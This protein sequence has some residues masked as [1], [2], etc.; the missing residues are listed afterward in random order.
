[1]SIRVRGTLA[2]ADKP[3]NEKV[4]LQARV[5][6]VVPCAWLSRLAQFRIAPNVERLAGRDHPT[7]AGATGSTEQAFRHAARPK[8][9]R[10]SWGSP[11]HRTANQRTARPAVQE[12]GEVQNHRPLGIAPRARGQGEGTIYRAGN[13]RL[14]SH[15]GGGRAGSRRHGSAQHPGEP[16]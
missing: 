8:A 10:T 1:M 6:G 11:K 5:S 3:T 14:Q 4:S 9:G 13:A 16:L 12:S 15:A 7:R 2:R